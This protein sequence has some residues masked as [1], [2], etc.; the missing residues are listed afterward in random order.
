MSP[1]RVD[2]EPLHTGAWNNDYSRQL[3]GDF[4][5]GSLSATLIAPIITVIDRS[6]VERLSSNRSLLST[7]RTHAFCSILKPKRFYL[8]RPFFIAWSL[9]AATYVTANATDTSLSHLPKLSEKSTITN[10]AATFSFLPTYVINVSLGILKDIRFS[11]IYGDP[12]AAHKRPPS[13]PRTAYM[14]FLLR[15]SITISSSFT[16]APQMASY[17]PDWITADLH[18]KRTIT[19]LVLPALVQFVNTPLHL[20]ALD[21]IA[22]PQVATIAERSALIRSGW[23][24]SSSVRAA[25][26][27][28]AFGIGCV[29]NAELR[30]F[31]HE[32]WMVR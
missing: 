20:M 8:S 14:A 6:V 13:I 32:R 2:A 10:I 22:R 23:I 25:R 26:I 18:T 29:V 21:L 7:L 17:I 15:D 3:A 9:Y 4:I 31:F 28:P 24:Q 5:A 12:N 11:Q 30:E 27:L 16:L 19:Q 1:D